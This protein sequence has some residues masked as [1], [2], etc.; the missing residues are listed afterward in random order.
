MG[1][2]LVL[3]YST[4]SP[5]SA[6]VDRLAG[7]IASSPLLRQSKGVKASPLIVKA[8]N[9]IGKLSP[10]LTLKATVNPAVRCL[11]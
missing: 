10:T 3:A 11:H 6:N 1:G 4:R 5:P 7:V 8:G 2:G 9:L